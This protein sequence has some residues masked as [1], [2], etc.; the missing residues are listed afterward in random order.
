MMA[1]TSRNIKKILGFL[2]LLL[3]S[4]AGFSQT[5]DY[6]L[7]V[8][9]GDTIVY[10]IDF[11]GNAVRVQHLPTDAVR[12][13][14]GLRRLTPYTREAVATLNTAQFGAGKYFSPNYFFS[15]DFNVNQ[16]N[17]ATRSAQG[18]S[19]FSRF[20]LP[21]QTEYNNLPQAKKFYY[22]TENELHG[23]YEGARYY[24]ATLATIEQQLYSAIA[25]GCYYWTANI[26]TSNEWSQWRYGEGNFGYDSWDVAKNRTIISERTGQPITLGDLWNSGQWDAEQQVRR[27]NRLSVMMTIARSRNTYAAY[28]A[29]MFQGEPRT[30]S[31]STTGIFKEG[32]A[33]V[34]HI[35]GGDGAGNIVL[36]GRSYT[37][38]N[39]N[40]YAYENSL[41]DYFYYF[42]WAGMSVSD[43][44]DIWV[45]R[46]DG[47]Q[48]M[49]YIW[50]KM[51]TY[52]IVASEVGH[53]LANR[54]RMSLYG[55]T[56]RGSVRMQEPNFEGQFY[57]SDGTPHESF[58]PFSSLQNVNVDGYLVTPKVF[59]PP[60]YTYSAYLCHRF[61]EGD[62][63][64]SGYHLWNAPGVTKLPTTHP[65]YQHHLHTVTGLYQARNDAQPLE[66]YYA[67]STLVTQPEVQLNQTG[68]WLSYNAAEA[69]GFQPDGGR[70]AQKPVYV[71]R[72]KPTTSGWQVYVLGGM[73]QD[74]STSR[75]DLIRVPGA[76]GGNLLRVKLTGPA[77]HI[78]EFA[79]SSSDT[80]QIYDATSSTTTAPAGYAGKTN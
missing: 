26:E 7:S 52:H 13:K 65:L 41:L 3:V 33:D 39:K 75:T 19:L 57:T 20:V 16:D 76:L 46:L 21:S 48:T 66:R 49:P 70:I 27:N 56:V 15:A 64:G 38:L 9:N 28:G 42:G 18:V 79:I 67:G 58:V 5:H 59:L 24:E 4:L 30:N 54:A 50:S 77:A 6:R 31:L 23:S 1:A 45:N 78:H 44:T 62:T 71:V 80:G 32:T 17:Y 37:G 11:A 51:P 22:Q 2:S 25:S 55:Q 35:P 72:W 43:Y 61:L 36:N 8:V 69:F 60:Y 68:S 14:R 12:S 40:V 53:W 47:T 10:K 29:S 73:N 63:P 34:S 74:W